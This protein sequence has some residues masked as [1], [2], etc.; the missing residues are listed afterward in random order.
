MTRRYLLVAAI[1]CVLVCLGSNSPA[2]DRKPKDTPEEVR[3]ARGVVDDAV[4]SA[5]IG[6]Y[7]QVEALATPRLRSAFQVD[8]S[9]LRFG[10][11]LVGDLRRGGFKSVAW[12]ESQ[13]APDKNEVRFTGTLHGVRTREV[14]E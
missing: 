14:G 7:E 13:L 6:E 12:T 8:S 9:S 5:F 3:W 2:G 4:A 11:S 10:M 1:G